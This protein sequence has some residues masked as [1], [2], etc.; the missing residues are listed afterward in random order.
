MLVLV[1]VFP[2]KLPIICHLCVFLTSAL[3]ACLSI[4]SLLVFL[5]FG[6]AALHS[7]TPRFPFFCASKE[8]RSLPFVLTYASWRPMYLF[9]II[10]WLCV[11]GTIASHPIPSQ[12]S[13]VCRILSCF[14]QPFVRSKAMMSPHSPLWCLL[15]LLRLRLHHTQT[16]IPLLSHI[17][18]CLLL[19]PSLTLHLLPQDGQTDPPCPILLPHTHLRIHPP[20]PL[21]KQVGATPQALPREVGIRKTDPRILH[22]EQQAVACGLGRTSAG[23]G[24]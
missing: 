10:L 3:F 9:L 14:S 18:L 22:I 1:L 2:C 11:T 19:M 6:R 20:I 5:P 21:S 15:Y 8:K 24:A 16:R 7:H 4:L 17:Q 23:L 13:H 12:S